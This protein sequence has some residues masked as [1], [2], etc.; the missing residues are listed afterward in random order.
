MDHIMLEQEHGFSH[1]GSS[2]EIIGYSE[3]GRPL[4]VGYYYNNEGSH[5][6]SGKK[7]PKVRVFVLAGQHGDERYGRKAVGRLVNIL[8]DNSSIY[9]REFQSLQIA[10]LQDANPDGASMRSRAN[11]SGIDLNRDHQFLNAAETRAM[12]SFIRKWRPHLVI[13]VHNYPSKRKHLLKKGLVL[14]HDVFVDVPTSP[15]VFANPCMNQKTLDQFLHEIRADLQLHGFSCERYCMIR[16]SGRV[17]HSTPDV[18]DARNFLTLRYNAMT[19]LL[20]GRTPTR[21]DGELKRE[22]LVAAQL[23]ALLSI[24]AWSVRNGSHLRSIS[25]YIP[26]KGERVPI[27]SRYAAARQAL[28]MSFKTVKSDNIEILSLPNYTPYLE[29]SR[30]VDLPAAYA[31]PKENK[32]LLN[33]LHRHGFVS[34]SL[35]SPCAERAAVQRYYIQSRGSK[36]ENKPQSRAPAMAAIVTAA[37]PEKRALCDDSYEI[38][39]SSQLG[40]HSLAILLEPKSKYGLCRNKRFG[41]SLLPE[42]Y[43]PILRVM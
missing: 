24:L 19:V 17:R 22:L 14:H 32:K 4:V 11:A 29:I 36:R 38:F 5:L 31:V 2:S 27:Q 8:D 42:S 23:Q 28:R 41:L 37:G 16:P 21:K 26:V 25:N 6:D 35:D 12:H 18:I 10:I 3:K 43:Y 20:E 1:P 40:G 39:P 30:Y 34:M 7:N 13:D 15:C 33:L 9:Q